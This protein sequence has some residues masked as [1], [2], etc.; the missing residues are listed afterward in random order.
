MTEPTDTQPQ[1]RF[2]DRKSSTPT[3]VGIGTRL[4]GELHCAGDLSVAGEVQGTG[5][6]QGMF[7]LSDTSSW[8]GT[9]HCA[10]ALVAGRLEG[11]LV[12]TGKLEIRATARIRGEITAH[13]VAIAEGA[14]VEAD[15]T[16]LSGAPVQHFEEKRHGD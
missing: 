9:I 12:V 1:R 11:E 7:T 4:E 16:V 8:Q 5:Q 14:V 3:L 10:R 13:Q 6:V 2:L 15:I